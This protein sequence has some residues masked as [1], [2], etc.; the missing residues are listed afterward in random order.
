LNKISYLLMPTSSIMLLD[1][2]FRIFIDYA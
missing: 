2:F 1:Q